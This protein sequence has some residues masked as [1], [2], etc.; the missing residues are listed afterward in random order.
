MKPN[1]TTEDVLIGATAEPIASLDAFVERA[2][3]TLTA[4]LW[5]SCCWPDSTTHHWQIGDF[6]FLIV[7]LCPSE[8][9]CLYVQFLSEPMEPVLMEVSSGHW[10]PGALKYVWHEQQRALKD[11]GFAIG[12]KA[13][14]FQ[15]S[16]SIDSP[17]ATE[18]IARETL[19]VVFDIFQYRGG[20]EL[21]TKMHYG[22]RAEEALVYNAL[23]PEDF[24]KIAAGAGFRAALVEEE[25]RFP[26]VTIGRRDFSGTAVLGLRVQD[27]SQFRSVL[28]N[29]VADGRLTGTTELV[30][31]G[32]ITR[33]WIEK[34]LLR[35]L[36]A[37]R[38]ELA[39]KR[40]K[41]QAGRPTSQ[42][43]RLV[44]H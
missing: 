44:V 17:E 43:N 20:C 24:V 25:K 26:L 42:Q 12:G 3:P 38:A 13:R 9:A 23:T 16:L 32:G 4:R 11:L 5:G 19:A 8:D 2:L 27:T 37:G 40:K 7:E 35:W 21:T 41:T 29:V 15:K 18:Q 22:R 39:N 1:W 34:R 28:L 14:N 31:E 36:S 6:R 10:N 30:L 33:R